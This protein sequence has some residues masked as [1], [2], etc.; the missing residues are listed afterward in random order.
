LT[1]G[2]N[3]VKFTYIFNR[4]QDYIADNEIKTVN[5]TDIDRFQDLDQDFDKKVYFGELTVHIVR[6]V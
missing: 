6:A 3:I 2:A 5:S 1:F 4:S